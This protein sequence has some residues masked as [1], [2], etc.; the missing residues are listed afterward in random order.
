MRNRL[1]TW[2]AVL[3]LGTGLAAGA[4][5]AA[6]PFQ[7][8]VPDLPGDI[9]PSFA[10]APAADLDITDFNV[11]FDGS[12]FRFGVTVAGDTTR[13]SDP[14]N[15][16]VIGIDFGT[17]GA[18]SPFG[19]IGEGAVTFNKAI[20]V[21]EGATSVTLNGHVEAVSFGADGFSMVVPLADLAAPANANPD[22]FGFSLWSK[23]NGLNV[24]GNP[25]GANAKNADFAPNNGV[26]GVPEPAAWALMILGFGFAG[27]GLRIRRKASPPQMA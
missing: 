10:G 21:T 4:A 11:A 6:T 22:N 24:T 18:A 9:L 12:N 3:A 15:Q 14:T 2:G 1:M 7:I 8:D 16:F 27:A 25:F 17:G 23:T 26:A 13:P 20:G 5:H 19:N